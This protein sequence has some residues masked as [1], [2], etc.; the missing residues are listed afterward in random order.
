VISFAFAGCDL[1][2]GEEKFN[3][4][5][6]SVCLLVELH[7]DTQDLSVAEAE[8]K[9]ASL[10][11]SLVPYRFH[12]PSPWKLISKEAHISQQTIG[13]CCSQKRASWLSYETVRGTQ[14]RTLFRV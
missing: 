6:L 11:R 4:L 8:R 14:I 2:K 1:P 12:E 5:V 9:L 10:D 13:D 7:P 3:C